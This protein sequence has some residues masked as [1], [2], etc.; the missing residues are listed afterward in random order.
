MQGVPG[1]SRLGVVVPLIG[2]MSAALKQARRALWGDN[3]GEMPV[4]QQISR[5][6][7]APQSLLDLQEAAATEG[8]RFVLAR[9][10]ASRPEWSARVVVT[11]V[12]EARPVESFF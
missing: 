2:R 7:E 6:D 5:M 12:P 1:E 10:R 8:A 4:L 9:L 3:Y 11:M